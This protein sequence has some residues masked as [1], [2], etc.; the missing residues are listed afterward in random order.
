MTYWLYPPTPTRS[1]RTVAGTALL[2]LFALGLTLATPVAAAGTVA[3]AS[4]Q[5]VR[6]G[7]LGGTH[8]IA[9]SPT[10]TTAANSGHDSSRPVTAHPAISLLT[11]QKFL[12][13]GVLAEVAQA[14]RTGSSYGCAGIASAHAIVRVGPGGTTCTATHAAGS[15]VTLDLKKIPA[16]GPVLAPI[17]R[18]RLR[19]DAIVS[20]A[21]DVNGT[22]T[23]TASVAHASLRVCL[24]SC[25]GGVIVVPISIASAPNQDLL[26]AIVDAL[27][28]HGGL[29]TLVSLLSRAVAPLLSITSNYQTQSHGVF[30]VTA[31]HLALLNGA[32]ASADLA[33]VTCGPN[34]PRG[35]GGLF[36]AAGLPLAI[37]VTA[38][39]A[40]I[41]YL[42]YR[43][44]RRRH[45]GQPSTV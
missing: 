24:L 20:Y 30:T 3:N 14:G 15:G 36:H 18:L 29:S 35:G 9:A 27:V 21:T 11:G 28:G 38:L 10:P 34:A 42:G 17:A 4:A 16:L 13:A 26:A 25:A 5:A 39:L 41:G 32:G 6:I 45:A 22:V 2:V 43:R 19:A 33:R 23:R 40:L 7:I 44:A 8:D 31:V 37:A 1:H 12:Q